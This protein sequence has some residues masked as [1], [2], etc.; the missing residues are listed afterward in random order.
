MMKGVRRGCVRLKGAIIGIDDQDVN[1]FTITVD[2]KTF[3]FQVSEIKFRW[4]I[5]AW[6]TEWKWFLKARDGEEREKWVRHLED[7]ITRSTHRRGVYYDTSQTL[8]SMG[9]SSTSGRLNNHLVVFDRKVS[10]ADTYLQMMIDQTTKIEQR[11]DSLES[12]EEREKYES[13]KAQAN[14]SSSEHWAIQSDND[15]RFF[16]FPISQ[17]MLDH[18]KHSIVLLQI[19]KVKVQR[20]PA[21]LSAHAFLLSFAEHCQPDKWHLQRADEERARWYSVAR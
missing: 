4:R 1:T 7:V 16:L 9:G 2:H 5:T 21:T 10:E 14:V 19:A 6:T 3:H 17:L 11:I 20:H 12:D 8:Q 13:L 18:I 15:L